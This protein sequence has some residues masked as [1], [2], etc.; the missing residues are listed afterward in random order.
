MKKRSKRL[1]MGA[2]LA[3]VVA[4][5]HR[6]GSSQDGCASVQGGLEEAETKSDIRGI[7]TVSKTDLTRYLDSGLGDADGLL[8]HGFMDGHL[9]LEVHLVKLI[10]ATHTL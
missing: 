3:A 4:S 6:V 8:L 7:K 2:T 9:V 10:N 1:M 5:T